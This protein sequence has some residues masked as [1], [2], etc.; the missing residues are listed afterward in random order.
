MAQRLVRLVCRKCRIEYIPDK[1]FL[2]KNGFIYDSG[3]ETMFY[4]TGKGCEDCR[5]T[6]YKGRTGIYELL[7]LDDDLRKT[8]LEKTSSGNI[9]KEAIVKG[10]T[11]LRQDGWRKVLSGLTTIEEVM[12]VTQEN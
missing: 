3:K 9:R 6:G 8:I 4:K 11:T 7:L 2:E 12:R 5:H 1:K 10:M